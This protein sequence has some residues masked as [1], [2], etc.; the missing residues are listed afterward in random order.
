[1]KVTC[2]RSTAA[3]GMGLGSVAMWKVQKIW[4]DS[5]IGVYRAGRG[6][7]DVLLEMLWKSL[8]NNACRRQFSE[9][10]SVHEEQKCMQ[11]N[12]K[13]CKLISFSFVTARFMN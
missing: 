1:M 5:Q 10:I 6:K 2:L 12:Q 13:F 11:E 7:V 4:L 3:L 9:S 8:R